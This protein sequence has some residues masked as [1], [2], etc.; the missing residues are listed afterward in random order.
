MNGFRLFLV[1][2]LLTPL[3]ASAYPIHRRMFTAVYKK[4]TRCELCHLRG[5]GSSRNSYGKAWKKLGETTQAFAQIEMLDS[6][7]DGVS[8]RDEI[9]QGSNPGDARSI[10]EAP[11]RRWKRLQ[12]VPIPTDQLVLV[13]KDPGK[14]EALERSLSP[15][16]AKRVEELAKTAL[17]TEDRLPTIYFSLR[18]KQRKEAA[19]FSYVR[20]RDQLFTLLIAVELTGKTGKLALFRAGD[21]MPEDYRPLL[22]CLSNRD[23]NGLDLKSTK[24]CLV[25]GVKRRNQQALITGTRKVLFTMKALFTKGG[26]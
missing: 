3:T 11:G 10:P 1:V 7:G 22:D 19:M 26:L 8:N 21:D 2:A 15:R 13:L 4:P 17:S 9:E 5:G 6:D 20:V 16:Q 14:I 12:R 18:G 23:L 24:G 25:K